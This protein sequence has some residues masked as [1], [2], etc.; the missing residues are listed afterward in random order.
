MR[1]WHDFRPAGPRPRTRSGVSAPHFQTMCQPACKPGSVW[2]SPSATVIRL[3]HRLRGPS[4]NQPGWRAWMRA[5]A[6]GLPRAP[7]PSLFGLAP[8]GV[9][10]ASDVAAAAVRSYR[11]VSPLPRQAE[12]CRGGLFSVALSLGSPP[13]AVS[14]HR[15]SMEPGLSS[16]G[17]ARGG[18]TATVQPADHRGVSGARRQGKPDFKCDFRDQERRA[19]AAVAMLRRAAPGSPLR[20]CTVAPTPTRPARCVTWLL[21][22][23]KHPDDDAVPMLRA[24][25]VPWMR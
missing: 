10:R 20:T 15:A 24:S 9:C 22:M 12:T 23:R 11:T 21:V 2:R 13:A 4:S 17:A 5:A 14:R 19:P 7:L 18:P 25:L 3:G 1:N 6:P 8:G 16:T